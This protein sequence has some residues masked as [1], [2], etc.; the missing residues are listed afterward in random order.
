MYKDKTVLITGG[1]RGIG[2]V[3]LHHFVTNGARVINIQRSMD[4]DTSNLSSANIRYLLCDI[5]KSDKIAEAFERIQDEDVDICINNA[6]VLTSQYALK[7]DLDDAENMIR[8]NLL[9]PFIITRESAKLMK[10]GGRIINISSMAV[11]LEP[12]GDSVYAACKAG[13]EKMGNIMA[14]EFNTFGITVN[15]LGISAIETDMLKQLNREKVDKVVKSLP[16][17][18]YAEIEDIINVI[19]FFC[20]P[21]SNYITAQ[22]VYLGGAHR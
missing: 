3:L 21:K 8:V 16:I 9:A 10:P 1:S 22:T 7:M 18:R 15:T 19:D 14:K 2:M 20:S 13:L 17:P 5:S 4:G 6:A 11:A 12:M